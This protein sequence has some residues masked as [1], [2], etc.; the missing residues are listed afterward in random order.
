MSRLMGGVMLDRPF[1]HPHRRLG[2]RALG[3]GLGLALAAA[4]VAP[5]AGAPAP[6]SGGRPDY[7]SYI[8]SRPNTV[9]VYDGRVWVRHAHSAIPAFARKYGLACSA[10]HT[11]WPELNAFGQRFKDNGYQLGNDRDSPIWQAPAYWPI[12]VRTTPQWRLER[13]T[14]Q[15][16]DLVPGDTAGGVAEGT[17]TQSG[18]DISGAD[19]LLLGTLYRNITFGF[20][21]TIDADGT[22]G[23]EAAFVRL[24]NLLKS[25]W[26]N[27]K[28]GKFELDNLLSEKRIVTLSGNGGLYQSYHFVPIGDATT[29]GLGDNQI[30][31]ELMGHS[32]NSYSR[33][34]L[35]VLTNTSGEPGLTA[36]GA[37]DGML[38]LSQAV[39]AGRLGI[40]RLGVFGYV[41]QRPTTFTTAG[42]EPV[43]GTG[44]NHKRFYRI[45][46]VGDFFLGNLE[47]L[48]F[49]VHASDDKYLA[50]GTPVGAPLPTGAQS[51]IWNGALLETHFY[52]GTQLL[53]IQRSEIVRMARQA[54]PDTPKSLGNVDAFTFGVRGYPIMFSRA[55][56]AATAEVAFSKTVGGVPLSGDGVG[57]PPLA[58]DTDVWSTSVLV[59]FDF[60]F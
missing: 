27:L 36:S 45:G 53:L 18:F 49:Y 34:S 58:P 1:Q 40:E 52:V 43:P 26:A 38:T 37:Y 35:A 46:A 31:A 60:A 28:L 57:L 16:I 5:A 14:H 30:G 25:S 29:F 3:L 42:G 7:A 12:A 4:P 21:P 20:V 51:P 19:L 56:L 44:T 15:P 17:V 8:R 55:G 2:P 39:D 41:G 10:C 23:I 33:Y 47:F 48:P 54:L 11:A 6:L 59:A 50:T 13:T 9:V 24:D 32:A 22:V